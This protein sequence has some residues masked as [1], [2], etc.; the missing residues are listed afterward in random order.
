MATWQKVITSGSMAQLSSLI[1]E[2]IPPDLIGGNVLTY[3]SESGKFRIT[4]SYGGSSS[5]ALNSTT[6]S[7]VNLSN[8]TVGNAD[9]ASYVNLGGITIDT[10]S[11]AT[12]AQNVLGSI[13]ILCKDCRSWLLG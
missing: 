1:V 4:G 3:I 13:L 2:N 10:A 12:T 9:T 8:V 5:Y 6:A 11:Y 7:Y